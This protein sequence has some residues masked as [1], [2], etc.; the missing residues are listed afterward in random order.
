MTYLSYFRQKKHIHYYKS[1]KKL[2]SMS[3]FFIIFAF[4][5]QLPFLDKPLWLDEWLTI[6]S[7]Q[8][9]FSERTLNPYFFLNFIV[10]NIFETQIVFSLR[11]LSMFFYLLSIGFFYFIVRKFYSI[12]TAIIATTC[13]SLLPLGSLMSQ[14]IRMYSFLGCVSVIHMGYT[15]YFIQNSLNQKPIKHRVFFAYFFITLLLLFTHF[16]GAL[17]L[18]VLTISFTTLWILKKI[19]FSQWKKIFFLYTLSGSI[20]FLWNWETI[21]TKL[22]FL[23]SEHTYIEMFHRT[24]SL[25]LDI[26]RL[27]LD[28]TIG[29]SQESFLFLSISL[30]VLFSF[31]LYAFVA[32]KLYIYKKV[33]ASKDFQFWTIIFITSIFFVYVSI[34]V[35]LLETFIPRHF[36]ILL[37]YIA[38]IIGLTFLYLIKT[39]T[40]LGYSF[41]LLFYSTCFSNILLTHIHDINSDKRRWNLIAQH[42]E[43]NENQVQAVFVAEPFLTGLFMF[44]YTGS[45]PILQMDKMYKEHS[46][47][48]MI[49]KQEIGIPFIYPEIAQRVLEELSPFQKV[50][51]VRT[52]GIILSD[53]ENILIR[54]IENK[55][56]SL[57][58]HC[59]NKNQNHCIHLYKKR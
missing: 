58:K 42:I 53:R 4:I 7:A 50:F 23:K 1:H 52:P 19:H 35:F 3:G 33:Y 37:P 12:R 26:F 8:K 41:L 25:F 43:R 28:I 13:F 45:L 22:G 38:L 17:L 20:F 18:F 36:F 14:E 57:N 55:Y 2:L 5:L 49:R 40:F 54:M 27:L 24:H 30:L 47:N 29:Y 11:L 48:K 39:N 21:F 32:K 15:L 56:I 16:S 31:L 59:V 9:I 44:H 46:S 6:D 34:N 51:I 10:Q